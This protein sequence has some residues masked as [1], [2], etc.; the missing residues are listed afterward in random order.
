MKPWA[1]AVLLASLVATAAADPPT[2]RVFRGYGS[3]HGLDDLTINALAQTSDGL[4]WVGTEDGLYAYDGARFIRYAVA[5]GLPSAE[6]LS[7]LADGDQLWVGTETGVARF[8]RAHVVPGSGFGVPSERVLAIA[9]APDG[10]VWLATDAGVFVRRAYFAFVADARWPGGASAALYVMSDGSV[11]AGRDRDLAQRRGD[12]S[13]RVLGAAA[14]FGRERIEQILTTSDDHVWLPVEGERVHVEFWAMPVSFDGQPAVLAI[15]RDQT[16]RKAI[17]ARLMF[18]DRMASIGTLAAGIAHEINNPLAYVKASLAHIASEA[19]AV[20][21]SIRGALDDALDGTQ[22]IAAIVGSVSTFSR[23]EAREQAAVD[24]PRAITAALRVVSTELN[25][26]CRVETELAATPLVS[27][28]EARIG[29]VVINLLINA[30]Q[31]MPARSRDENLVT[32]ATRTAPDG[33]AVIE[34]RDNGSGMSPEV[35]RRVFEPFFTTKD[36]GQ[37]SGLGLAVCHGIV[38]SYGGE[39]SVSSAPGQGATFTVVLPAAAPAAREAPARAPASR[40]ARRAHLLVIDDD[41][42]LLGSL[43]RML[44]RS[45]DVTPCAS[46]PHALELLATDASI[47]AVL[48]DLMMPGFTGMQLHAELL[49]TRPALARRI[50]F[51]TGGAFTPEAREFVDQQPRVLEKPFEVSAVRALVDE[52]VT[53]DEIRAA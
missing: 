25:H 13:W 35:V 24:L 6:V 10:S 34:V 46:G 20:A 50:I 43:C 32:L 51:M 29:Q 41:A 36:V 17:E 49:R 21:P 40:P 48:C 38:T 26:R 3:E 2:R 27:A 33:R 52:L 30:A 28:N 53:V 19:G 22:R 18:S 5:D 23:V 39:V 47:D 42:R 16:E 11:V 9:R 15:G 44:Q 8:S 12:G 37:G 4:M 45:Y 14:G 1:I 31:A 7:L